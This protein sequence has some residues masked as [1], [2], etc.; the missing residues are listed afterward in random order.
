VQEKKHNTF[1]FIYECFLISFG[2]VSSVSKAFWYG[3]L[4]I[5][6]LDAPKP[7]EITPIPVT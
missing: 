6:N 7:I 2:V 3:K 1:V 5:L 4:T